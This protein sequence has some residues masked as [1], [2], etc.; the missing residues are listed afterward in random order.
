[1]PHLSIWVPGQLWTVALILDNARNLFL[2][3]VLDI[4][5]HRLIMIWAMPR[6]RPLLHKIRMLWDRFVIVL[7]WRVHMPQ[8]PLANHHHHHRHPYS[9]WRSA[10]Q[11]IYFPNYSNIPSNN[12]NEISYHQLRIHYEIIPLNSYDRA[13]HIP[14]AYHLWYIHAHDACMLV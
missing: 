6:L 1:M 9:C 13:I 14:P 8:V 11:L 4:S 10:T 12:N 2:L 7:V 3:H 5:L